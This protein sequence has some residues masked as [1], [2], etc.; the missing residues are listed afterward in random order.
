MQHSG[1]ID[2]DE[3]DGRATGGS[4]LILDEGEV[5]HVERV[6]MI[7]LVI[8]RCS[9]EN[10]VAPKVTSAPCRLKDA[11]PEVEGAP[12]APTTPQRVSLR[13]ELRTESGPDWIKEISDFNYNIA[14]G[15]Q[16]A[17]RRRS[18]AQRGAQEAGAL[19]ERTAALERDREEKERRRAELERAARKEAQRAEEAEGALAAAAEVQ[20]ERDRLDFLEVER[21]AADGQAPV[22]PRPPRAAATLLA[23]LIDRTR[24]Q[25]LPAQSPH[26]QA[27]HAAPLPPGHAQYAEAAKLRQ[28]QAERE[29]RE[30]RLARKA[31]SPMLSPSCDR[32]SQRRKARLAAQ[33]HEP[34]PKGESP[35]RVPDIAALLERQQSWLADRDARLR[36]AA[37]H[38]L[39]RQTEQCTFRPAVVSAKLPTYVAPAAQG[40]NPQAALAT[41]HV[42]WQQECVRQLEARRQ[43]QSAAELAACTFHPNRSTRAA[44][45]PPSPA[46]TDPTARARARAQWGREVWARIVSIDELQ[47]QQQGHERQTSTTVCPELFPASPYDYALYAEAE[48]SASAGPTPKKDTPRAP[49]AA[50]APGLDL[51]TTYLWGEGGSVSLLDLAAEI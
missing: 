17:E 20:R 13:C 27:P 9:A 46:L 29:Q 6:P 44:G 37:A 39:R 49:S 38:E 28:R 12:E 21:V 35:M 36:D 25:A 11:P 4:I 31:S 23:A 42:R 7:G 15:A 8:G 26:P 43:H 22:L 50:S 41:R 1:I 14:R 19:A 2:R 32:L 5:K 30:A 33:Q 48:L 47:Q 51:L 34:P 24:Y 16:V 40:P 10:E 3:G 45:S 18:E